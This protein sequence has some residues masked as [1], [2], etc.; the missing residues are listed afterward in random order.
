MWAILDKD[1]PIENGY[2]IW[3]SGMSYPRASVP[4]IV[5][6]NGKKWD[7]KAISTIDTDNSLITYLSAYTQP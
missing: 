4:W 3:K 1:A 6:S 5:L 7:S 2:D